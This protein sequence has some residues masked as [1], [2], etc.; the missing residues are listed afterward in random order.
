MDIYYIPNDFRNNVI[1]NNTDLLH[2]YLY[3]MIKDILVSKNIPVITKNNI[4]TNV[5]LSRLFQGETP[6]MLTVSD[7][8]LFCFDIFSK[9]DQYSIY[10]QE[11]IIS[12]RNKY[13]KVKLFCDF[14]IIDIVGF[15]RIA[16]FRN[17]FT[18]DEMDFII[19]N[20]NIFKRE[21]KVGNIIPTNNNSITFSIPSDYDS[22]VNK[23][24]SHLNNIH[25]T[26]VWTIF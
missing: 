1:T 14:E 17:L 15:K 16:C 2:D 4:C 12:W 13:E 18:D 25:D 7:G 24:L 6:D 5:I 19:Q 23:L 26:L 21:Y 22:K 20:Y 9:H 8:K 3:F 11:D 10:D